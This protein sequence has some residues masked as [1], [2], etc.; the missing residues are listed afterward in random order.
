MVP[1]TPSDCSPIAARTGQQI[2]KIKAAERRLSEMDDSCCGT[3]I[4]QCVVGLVQLGCSRVLPPGAML[5]P[6]LPTRNKADSTL[7]QI[8]GFPG[9]S[10]PAE[11]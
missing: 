7:M 4:S 10:S 9:L 8:C 6:S 3:Q 5:G 2:I 1:Q 11:L